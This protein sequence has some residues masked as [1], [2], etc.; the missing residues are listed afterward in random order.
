MTVR[1]KEKYMPQIYHE[2]VARE[3]YNRNVRKAQMQDLLGLITGTNT[4]LVNFE[5]LAK[6][7]NIRQEVG[8][9]LEDV[10]VEKIVGSLGRYH[11]FTREFLPRARVNSD[12]WARLDAALNALEPIPPVDLYK[13]GEVYFV[14]DGNHRVSVARANRI[15][16]IEAYVTEL[17]SPILLT[18]SDFERERWIIKMEYVD[19]LQETRLDLLRPGAD[20]LLTVPG[21]YPI[22]LNHIHVH[23]YLQNMELDRRGATHRLGPSDIVMSWYDT[24]YLPV[25]EAIRRYNLLYEFPDRSEADLY[26]WI[27]K[28][29][30]RLSESFGLGPLSPETAVST[31]AEL[32]SEKPVQRTLKGIKLGLHRTLG[33]EKPLGMSDEEF[34]DAR[35]RHDAGELTLLEAEKL[36]Q[37]QEILEAEAKDFSR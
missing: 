15:D 24:I 14:Q 1:P 28:H 26:L 37:E 17:A 3:R 18:L 36:L 19:F 6:R 32:Y 31:F 13:I 10:P 25:V 21:Q 20:L 4:N 8:R 9:R 11:D 16:T 5:E 23:G 30:E 35:A 33:D 7:L 22:I 12:R 29:R 2:S 34:A 27:T